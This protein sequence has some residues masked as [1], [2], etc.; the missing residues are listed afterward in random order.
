VVLAR[1]LLVLSDKATWRVKKGPT[2]WEELIENYTGN[3]ILLQKINLHFFGLPGLSRNFEF[4][5]DSSQIDFDFFLPCCLLI[6]GFL[7]LPLS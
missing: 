6:I 7:N 5:N 2:T 1:K 3:K 4:T